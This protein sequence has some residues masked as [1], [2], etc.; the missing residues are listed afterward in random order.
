MKDRKLHEA[1]DEFCACAVK[2]AWL[3]G[4]Y[5]SVYLRKT[6]RWYN[7]RR[8]SCIDLS[9]IRDMRE[10]DQLQGIFPE[11]IDYLES[12]GKTIY[13]ENVGPMQLRWYFERRG[14]ERQTDIR[15]TDITGPSY[16]RVVE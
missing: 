6:T 16:Y 9:N 14:Y 13:V 1:L 3:D 15:R 2:N 12:K 5:L 8:I 10:E 11:F 4:D 7:N